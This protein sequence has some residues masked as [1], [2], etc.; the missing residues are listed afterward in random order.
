MIVLPA[1]ILELI[2]AAADKH[3]VRRELAQAVA[4]T[5]SRGNPALVSPRGAKGVM[6]LMDATAQALGV[7]DP[8]DAS[9]NVDGGVRFLAKLTQRFGTERKALAA[10][11]WGPAR[12]NQ[13]RPWPSQVRSYVDRVLTLAD[14]ASK[15][16]RAEP[17]MSFPDPFDPGPVPE[18][19]DKPGPF[20][21]GAQPSAQPSRSSSQPG[22]PQRFAADL[23]LS[24][25]DVAALRF[26]L[27]FVHAMLMDLRQDFE[28]LRAEHEVTERRRV[29]GSEDDPDFER[30]RAEDEVTER[31][32]V[33]GSEEREDAYG[34]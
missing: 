12:V 1:E 33:E 25:E 27:R 32:R 13:G 15:I 10:Y 7:S 20:E 31:R 4:W 19:E 16:A 22:Q 23:I 34:G 3:G 6:Q 9:Q 8:F 18:R 11:N 5:E 28:R 21:V 26:G 17:G 29:E 30:V 14:G 24:A 2:N